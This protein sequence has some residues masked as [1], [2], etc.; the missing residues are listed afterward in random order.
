MTSRSSIA[1]RNHFRLG[2][3]CLAVGVVA[4]AGCLAASALAQSS[5]RRTSRNSSNQ[6]RGNNPAQGLNAF[7]TKHYTI[8]TDARPE[9]LT[10]IS[11]HM[12]ALF[13]NYE[14]RFQ[15]FQN[16]R[17]DNQKMPLY[18][19]RT[20]KAYTDFFERLGFSG[21]N[22]GG[23][24][25]VMPQAQGLAIFL[26]GRGLQEVTSVLQHEGFHQFAFS[27]IGPEL[28]T[29]V[30]EGIAQYF[31]DG[32]LINDKFYLGMA[33]AHRVQSV[34]AA[35]ES[36]RAIDFNRLL[37]LSNQEWIQAVVS[38]A[39]QASLQYDQSWSIVYFLITAENGKY[40]VP[41]DNYL[42][43]VAKGKDSVSA[44]REAF[45]SEDTTAFEKRWREWA[46]KVQPDPLSQAIERMSY[47]A[48]AMQFLV[49]NK[50]AVPNTTE[51]LRTTLQKYQFR[52]TLVSH[53][54]VRTEYSADNEQLYKY[55][56]PNGRDTFFQ[57]LPANGPGGLPRITANLLSPQPTLSWVKD[58]VT[59][60]VFYDFTFTHNTR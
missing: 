18:I 42:R 43:L 52:L 15:G 47:M 6:A 28:P 25:F 49:K 10:K 27:Y 20:K 4:L 55:R 48:E 45:G 11:K 22:T 59:G 38:G 16:N 7:T 34:K 31:E 24:F 19:F 60:Q 1:G 53:H 9:D 3:T 14:G 8:Y 33:N 54:G 23:M 13:E 39:P 26:E 41:F 5:D 46:L 21:A 36:N 58:P 2:V 51:G 30:N 50:I 35:I 17:T 57:M 37:S 32:I 29:W 40:R 56:N 12:D 44:F